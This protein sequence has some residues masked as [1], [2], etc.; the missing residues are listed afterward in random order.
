VVC[1]AT[2]TIYVLDV[3]FADGTTASRSL[4][5]AVTPTG[6]V[7]LR[8]WAEQYT[9]PS[10]ACTTLHWKVQN[11]RE[12]YLNDQGVPGVGAVQVCP[13]AS[14]PY[15]LRVVD[16]AGRTGEHT[17]VLMVGDPELE[18]SEVIAQGVVNNVVA[19]PDVD[20]NQSGDQ[21]GYRLVI[22]GVNALFTGTPGWA[23]AAVALRVPQS[24]IQSGQGSP[25]DWPIVAS[26]Q[27]EFR[28]TCEGSECLLQEA[29]DV[30]LRLRSE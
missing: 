1:P 22:D 6:V 16:W 29:S 4:T 13:D 11:V 3:E 2:D 21:M 18:A 17:I 15:T 14:R 20:P 26:Q 9:L 30:Y 7:V 8:F 5:I 10:G 27:V 24:L 25:V 19:V 28:S 12:V 23:Q